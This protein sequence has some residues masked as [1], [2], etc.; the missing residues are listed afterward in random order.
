LVSVIVP[1]FNQGRYIR[2][3]IDSC[4]EQDWKKIEVLVLD[5]A[6]ADETVAILRG[7]NDPRLHWWSEPDRGVVDAVNKGL[8]RAK[9]DFLTIQSSDDMFLPGAISA[10]VEK[11][12]S[13][14]SLGLVF[15]DV[16]HIDAESRVIRRD[17]LPGFSVHSYLGRFTYIPQP[18]TVF[19]REAM[20]TAGGWRNA[21]SYAADADFWMRIA[22]RFPVGKLSRFV[23]RYR[24]HPAQR[25]MQRASIARD[26]ASAV[27]DLLVSGALSA[28][29]RRY[30]RMGVHLANYRYSPEQDWVL[31]T[32]ELYR[33]LL[34]N[35]VAVLDRRFPKRELLPGRA[36]IWARLSRIK[37]AMGFKPRTS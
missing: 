28:R 23:A 2:E 9:G 25:D 4:L 1:S 15:G 34:A 7:L 18:G 26:W 13:D 10:A 22:T 12:Q 8:E 27:D 32:R 30:A 11:L 6:S 20:Q 35:P 16:E 14:A 17:V 24:H 5:G 36:P 31:R 29:E 21:Y 37:R 19:T 3:T 33:A